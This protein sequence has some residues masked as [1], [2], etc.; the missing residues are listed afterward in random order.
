MEHPHHEQQKSNLAVSDHR[1]VWAVFSTKVDDDGNDEGGSAS[2]VV[3]S[4]ESSDTEPTASE[5]VEVYVTRTGKKYHLGSCSSLRRG[6]I[7]ISLAEAKQRYG[8]CSRC[9]P[10]Q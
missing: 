3:R 2:A 6:K 5:N 1:P 4:S 10:P 8:A 9:N 7:P